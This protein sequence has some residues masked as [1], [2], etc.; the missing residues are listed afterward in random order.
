M[1]VKIKQYAFGLLVLFILGALN[2][3]A[4]LAR[5]DVNQQGE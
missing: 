4:S 1:M 5:Q 2:M 3:I